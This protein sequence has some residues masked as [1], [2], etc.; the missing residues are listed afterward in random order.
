MTA[1]SKFRYVSKH[2]DGCQLFLIPKIKHILC[3]KIYIKIPKNKY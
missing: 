3:P 1:T 2:F